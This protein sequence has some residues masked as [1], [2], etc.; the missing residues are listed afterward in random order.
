MDNLDNMASPQDSFL[1]LQILFFLRFI[2]LGSTVL[3]GFIACYFVWWH[4]RLH[5]EIPSGLTIVICACSL[6]FLESYITSA[7]AH[8][9][10]D[11]NPNYKLLL[12]TTVPSAIAMAYG[13]WSLRQVPFV[14]K[15]CE[16]DNWFRPV[17]YGADVGIEEHHCALTCDIIVTGA[18]ALSFTLFL[19][20]FAIV[21]VVGENRENCVKL[22]DRPHNYTDS[23]LTGH[24]TVEKDVA[25]FGAA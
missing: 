14:R 18:I 2:Q 16:G 1:A 23:R 13:Y 9:K 25:L 8:S 11:R 22:E 7:Y 21:G 5:D 3:T 10:R 24:G 12:R 19:A 20:V 6:A 15:W 17:A 4:D